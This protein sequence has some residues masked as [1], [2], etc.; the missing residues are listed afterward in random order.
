MRATAARP[1]E[2]IA[3]LTCANIA[4]TVLKSKASRVHSPE[5][6]YVGFWLRVWASIIDSVLVLLILMP[7]V[8]AYRGDTDWLDMYAETGPT[9]VLVQ[10]VLPALAV[11][12]FW[13]TRQATPGKMA[14]GATIVDADSGKHPS[15]AQFLGRYLAYYVSMIP[16]CL[17]FLWVG[18]DAR[19]QG[20]HDKLA[21]TVV[22]RPRRAGAIVQFK[23]Q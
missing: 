8:R 13:V 17:G 21:G 6:E 16:L 2:S 12:I 1:P 5:L 20:W 14:I 23:S 7:F 4:T 15:T 3:R 10:W 22:V 19:K 9:A 18:I 11:L